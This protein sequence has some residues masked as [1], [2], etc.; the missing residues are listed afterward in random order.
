MVD[1]EGLNLNQTCIGF[2]FQLFYPRISMSQVQ[3]DVLPQGN[4]D[5]HLARWM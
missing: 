2:R 3:M 1:I 5:D 4:C